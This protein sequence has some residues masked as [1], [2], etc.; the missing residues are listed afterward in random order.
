MVAT[1]TAL[2]VTAALLLLAVLHV[3]DR[4]AMACR[5]S[6]RPH[7]ERLLIEKRWMERHAK[8]PAEF[9]LRWNAAL[10]QLHRTHVSK[11]RRA[12]FRLGSFRQV[13]HA[14]FATILEREIASWT[15]IDWACA[16]ATGY[17][18]LMLRCLA[19]I[20]W[21]LD[22][23]EDEYF[24]LIRD[25][26]RVVLRFAW[27]ADDVAC[28]AIN[29]AAAAAERSG[30]PAAYVI[31]N[32]RF[33]GAARAMAD[34]RHVIAL[35]CSQFDTLTAAPAAEMPLRPRRRTGLLLAA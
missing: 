23:Q 20:G 12:I 9:A 6:L 14:E 15:Y 24:V 19:S 11:P 26:E 1:C 32:G 17:E 31:T 5:G 2:W 16:S 8:G 3:R 33:S 29:E 34:A 22:Y 35:H 10:A 30:C 27:S 25:R 28:L 4:I 13:L 7:V 18:R 21:R